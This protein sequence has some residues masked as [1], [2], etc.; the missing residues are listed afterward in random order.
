MDRDREDFD[1]YCG[2]LR[3]TWGLELALNGGQVQ[4]SFDPAGPP[5]S[6]PG[7]LGMREAADPDRGLSSDHV[8]LFMARA[9][10]READAFR[11]RDVWEVGC[12]TGLLSALF[13]RLGAR[14]LRATDVDAGSLDL[15]RA[16]AE[17]NGVRIETA[18]AS[19]FEG[20]PWREPADILVAD[21]PQKPSDRPGVPLSQDGGPEG[22]RLLVPFLEESVRWLR[23]DGRLYFFVHTLPHPTALRRLHE[24]YRIRLLAVMRR[25]FDAGSFAGIVPYLLRRRDAGLC[26]FHDHDDGRH[27]FFGMVFEGRPRSN[28]QGPRSGEEKAIP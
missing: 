24:L 18:Q 27:S 7:A 4:P 25:M 6:A 17:L 26:H 16:T 5:G 28:V 20:A 21:L 8:T 12:G 11:G 15:A 10:E 14:R 13:G 3:R 23:P 22:T 2:W 1:R 9:L 19:L